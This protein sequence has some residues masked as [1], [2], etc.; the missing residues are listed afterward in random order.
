MS[1]N[2][3]PWSRIPQFRS[4]A[5]DRQFVQ[6]RQGTI[7]LF[8]RRHQGTIHY[9]QAASH[10]IVHHRVVLANSGGHKIVSHH[11]ILDR[12]FLQLKAALGKERSRKPHVG[13]EYEVKPQTVIK[14]SSFSRSYFPFH[15]KSH[16]DGSHPYQNDARP[17]QNYS[18]VM[19]HLNVHALHNGSSC[20]AQT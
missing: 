13:C 4:V 18:V 9:Q 6:I 5:D 10:P 15:L 17:Q 11:H 1:S 3:F 12:H 2:R 19:L 16:V 20:V 7:H 14:L 8:R